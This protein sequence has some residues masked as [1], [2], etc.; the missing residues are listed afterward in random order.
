MLKIWKRICS[1]NQKACAARP[2]VSGDS[3]EEDSAADDNTTAGPEA[4]ESSDD[5]TLDSNGR[6]RRA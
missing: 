4:V 2:A 5:D 6:D 3:D 1:I